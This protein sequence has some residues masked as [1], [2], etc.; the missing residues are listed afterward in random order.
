MNIGFLLLLEFEQAQERE[1]HKKRQAH[2]LVEPKK[3]IPQNRSDH[4]L[5]LKFKQLLKIRQS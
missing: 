1:R 4:I 3:T 2:Q 5:G